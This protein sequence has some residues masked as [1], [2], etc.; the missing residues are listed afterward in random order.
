MLQNVAKHQLVLVSTGARDWLESNGEMQKVD[1]GY[2][3]SGKKHFASQSVAGDVVVTSAPFLNSESKWKVLHF[4]VPLNAKGI[5]I[6]DDWHVMGMR[7]TGSQTIT[8][9]EVFVPDTAI[10]LERPRGEFHA[11]W[12]MVLTVAMPLIMSSYMGI[13]EKAME[14][15]IAAG[16]KYPRNQNHLAYMVGKLNNTLLS[17]Q[18]QWKAMCALTNNLDFKLSEAITIDIL[19][20][21]TNIADATRQAVGEAMEA[22]GGQSFYE[23]N[24]L[25]RLF[26]DVQASPFHP[27]PKWAQYAFTGER[28]LGR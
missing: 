5:G 14:I 6:L 10:V 25:E 11:V 26:R 8:F 20:Y 18:A 19:S 3:L 22:T 17:A 9:D 21:K 1:G 16:K 23:K 7:G 15:A 13:A 28:L 12:N 24:V 27:L 4:S 2:I